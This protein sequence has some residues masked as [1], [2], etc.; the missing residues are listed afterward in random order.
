[1][2]ELDPKRVEP[3]YENEIKQKNIKASIS[4]ITTAFNENNID[5]LRVVPISAYAEYENGKRVYDN[6]WNVDN[7][8]EYLIDVLPNEAQV[9]MVRLAAVTKIQRKVARKLVASTAIVCAGIAATPIPVADVIPIT[10]A[11]IAMIIGIGYIAG[12]P[13]SKDTANQFMAALGVNVGAGFALREA[14]RALIKFVFPGGG[15]VVSA[16]VAAAG[17]WAI[18]EAAI[19]YFIENKSIEAAKRSGQEARRKHSK[20]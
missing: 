10:T 4:A 3:P 8:V 13:L 1:M 12:K 6:C 7:L 2:D 9:E 15:N 11:Q 14:A 16:G 17:T 5:L 18:G 19:A 20:D